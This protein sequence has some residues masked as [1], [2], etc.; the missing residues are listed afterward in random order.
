MALLNVDFRSEILRIECTM[1]V[2]IPQI[3]MNDA[4]KSDEIH[5]NGFPVLYLLHGLSDNHTA[6]IRQTSI[7]RYANEYGIAVVMPA[8]NRSFYAD[9]FHG[10]R[11]F[12]FISEELPSIVKNMFPISSEPE[13]TYVA[14]LSMGGYGAF[15]LA[16]VHPR[17]F[18]A[19][20]SLSGA[21]NMTEF[22]DVEDD[23]IL[24]DFTILYG[25]K[26]Q[27]L[28]SDNYLLPLL[29]K[30]AKESEK[31]PRLYQCCGTEDFLYTVNKNFLQYASKLG[32]KIFYE[33]GPG[34][35]EWSFWDKYIQ[36]V[37]EWMFPNGRVRQDKE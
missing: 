22:F 7:E 4:I 1:S 34:E 8:V 25:T 21:L 31:L 18:A 2:I 19:A 5:K 9:M 11:Y 6:W 3:S 15:K 35:H 28:N 36:R 29:E 24:R 16:L 23:E 27:Y 14:G 13:D 26:E 32:I 30:R 12:T 33:E 20:A 17:R 37:L 10:D